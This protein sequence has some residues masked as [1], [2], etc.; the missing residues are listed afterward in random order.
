MKL[1]NGI[2]KGYTIL[3]DQCSQE[4]QDKL[5][6]SNDWDKVQWEQSLH[7]LI[8]KIKRICA[9]F[10]NHKQENFTL[11]QALKTLFLYI[12]GKKESMEEYLRNFE[13]LWDTVEAFGG[14]PGMQKGLIK[15]LLATT[16]RVANPS[17]ITAAEITAAE[18]E[19]AKAVKAAM[20]ISGQTIGAVFIKN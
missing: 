5:E 13:S 6:T 4:V 3:W 14:S 1:D 17:K 11:M 19:V 16:G 2:K 20:L 7:H 15:G 9:G 18:E 10:D 8:T 12:K